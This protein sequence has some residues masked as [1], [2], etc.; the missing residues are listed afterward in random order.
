MIKEQIFWLT[1]AFVTNK[2]KFK[3]K[4]TTKEKLNAYWL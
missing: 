2:P 4:K 1:I 3:K